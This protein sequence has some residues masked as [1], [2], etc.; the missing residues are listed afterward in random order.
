MYGFQIT[1]ATLQT[2]S[3]LLSEGKTIQYGEITFQ[4]YPL[5]K[6]EQDKLFYE[7]DQKIV[8]LDGV[9]F[10]KRELMEG[11]SGTWKDIF[12]ELYR[13]NPNT[14]FNELRGSFC[15]AVLEKASLRLTAFTNHSGEKTVYYTVQNG[16]F[17]VASHNNILTQTLRALQIPVEPDIRA[18]RELIA[19]GSILAGKTPFQRVRRV[20][21]GKYVTIFDGT[22]E[23][24]RYHMF[25]NVPEHSLSLDECI[26]ELDK[27]FRKA[28]DRI[29]SKN[30]EYGY[31]SECDLSAGT[32][33][34][35]VAWVA[36]DLGYQNII[37]IC[38]C[39]SGNLDH[40]VS[41]KIAHR[42]KNEYVFIPMDG[43]DFL[44]EVDEMVD[45]F[46]G[47]VTYMICTGANQAM[48]K[49]KNANVAL[50]ATGLLGELAKGDWAKDQMHTPPCYIE[51]RY[52]PVVPLEPSLQELGQYDN[53]EQ[54][55]F[56]EYGLTLM[57]SSLLIRQQQCEGVSPFLDVDCLE[58]L[59]RIPIQFRASK[60]LIM[61]WMVKKY[62]EA[63]KYVWLTKR[64]PVTH[65]YYNKIYWPKVADDV[66]SFLVRCMNKGC[67]ICHLP[68][69][70]TYK[71]EMNPVHTWYLTNSSLRNFMEEYYQKNIHLIQDEELRKVVET[72]Y[73]KGY[74]VDRVQA[75]NLLAVFKRYFQHG[76]VN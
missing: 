28:V 51:H 15:G 5:P 33:S 2:E 14:F 61:K 68:I 47:Q 57:Y 75:I 11:K 54:L 35:L 72:T 67:R 12:E 22:A 59:F 44:T 1:N 37:N 39:H 26:E 34:R 25:C 36:H 55:N 4:Y 53:R 21:A 43:G 29:F 16:I 32:D 45:K 64:M 7:D 76:K 27:R 58:F 17:I 70:M 48:K 74:G 23:E 63:A 56:Y 46:G 60:Q 49:I 3:T 41:Q 52:S 65:A 13:E 10:N 50:C 69:Q 40:T 30:E 24:K 62:P 9:I 18:C 73:E 8:L 20:F 6:F 19:Y 42:L 31:R 38:Y 71:S 66:R